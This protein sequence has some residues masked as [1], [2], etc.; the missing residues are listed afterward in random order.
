MNARD[1]F[2]LRLATKRGAKLSLSDSGYAELLLAVQEDPTKFMEDASD[3]A[4]L[5]IAQALRRYNESRSKDEFLDDAD[6]MRERKRRLERMRQDC[7]QALEL[8]PGCT[9]ALLLEAIAQDSDLDALL[10]RLLEVEREA[11]EKDGPLQA[12]GS[13]DA[14]D[15]V[16]VRPRLRVQATISRTCLDTGRFRMADAVGQSLI[17][18]S[19]SDHLGARHTCALALARLEDEEAFDALDAKFSRRGD[20]WLQLSRVILL[21]KLGRMAAA[22]RALRGFRGL[23]EGGI[24]A[25]LRP[26]MVDTYM[27][28]RPQCDSY[29]F[30]EAT[31]AIHE[32]DPII[33]D[34][35][36]LPQW[37]EN[38]PDMREAAMSFAQRMGFDW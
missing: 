32:A 27:P 4:F 36:D 21:F 3:E 37:V 22:R 30:E 5:C 23:C 10:D 31:V 12:A 35:P 24:Y 34:V 20:C 14:W 11:S 2:V 6:F 38:Q 29:S 26:V 8:D 16:M 13:G 7:A 25:L 18:L 19:H 28:D 9:D 15:D 1:E 17:A 33:V